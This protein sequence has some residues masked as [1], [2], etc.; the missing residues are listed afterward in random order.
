MTTRASPL[1]ARLVAE[2]RRLLGEAFAESGATPKL[3]IDDLAYVMVRIGESF[4]WREFISGEQPD[5]GRA[6]DVVS[7][8]LG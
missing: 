4:S 7:V 5:V 3:P 2:N 6:V 1:Q 8:L